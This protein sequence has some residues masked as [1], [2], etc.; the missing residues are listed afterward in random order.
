MESKGSSLRKEGT[1][2]RP[3]GLAALPPFSTSIEPQPCRNLSVRLPTC[4]QSV[5]NAGFDE[6]TWV[7]LLY[8]HFGAGGADGAMQDAGSN[9][10]PID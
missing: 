10:Y 4:Q 2:W 7:W 5:D 9:S 8:A 3:L 6:R 1:S